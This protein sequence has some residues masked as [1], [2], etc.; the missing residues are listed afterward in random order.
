M[1]TPPIGIDLGTTHSL[2]AAFSDG[3][4]RLIP[5][6]LGQLLTPSVVSIDD[7]GHLLIGQA[8]KER[9][10]T[11]PQH[12]VAAFKRNMGTAAVFS[13]AG[14]QFTAE[15]LS[16]LV[17][18]KLKEDAEQHLGC[19]ITEAVVSVP[20]YFNQTQ[21]QA[22]RSACHIAGIQPIKLINEP[23]AAAL[24]YGLHDR[25]GESQFLVLDLGGGTFD[26]T[27]LEHFD[28]VMEVK[29]SSGD[30]FL[31][32]EDF[33]EVLAKE[34]TKQLSRD[35]SAL[36]TEN[37]HKLRINAEYLK[38]QLS[39]QD[40]LTTH[41]SLEG[42][43]H[44]CTIT[45]E[46]FEQ[47]C[48]HLRKR[49]TTP[50]ERCFYDARCSAKDLDRVVMV[51]G[52]TRMTMFRK[53][54]SQMLGIF[55][56]ALLHPDHAVAL[57]AAVQ[58]GLCANNQALD[59]IVM[60]DVSP[61]SV[62][63]EVANDI[64]GNEYL[65]GFFQPII[66]RNTPLPASRERSF[67]TTKNNQTT[68]LVSLYQGEAPKVIDNIKLGDLSIK[69]PP[70]KAGQESI[71]VRVTYDSSGLIELDVQSLS[72]KDSSSLLITDNVSK[73]NQDDIAKSLK[74]MA[75]LKI[76]PREQEENRA[77]LA[78]LSRL[79]ASALGGDREYIHTLLIDFERTLHKQNP[80]EIDQARNTLTTTLNH[81]D[82]HYVD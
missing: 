29:A 66:E 43:E 40:K 64:V 81:I 49:L 78:R 8:A 12:S 7:N 25:D 10:S 76:H 2:I 16:A 51:G 33:T 56:E 53:W 54:V 70:A 19:P 35:W 24:A 9:L 62:G 38:Q 50:I 52:A 14:T 15:E 77:M 80:L 17:L 23:T 36:S 1:S 27:I 37:Q 6:A 79:Y 72:T 31:G 75:K 58:A 11:H 68:I 18:K 20:A 5:N 22:T 32:G 73:P 46:Q 13:L 45:R 30:A 3:E 67:S 42:K 57:G 26:V 34:L 82:E 4:A 21:R 44:N 60:T 47:A 61:F 48:A 41:F 63:I 55:P 28:G 71:S 65:A 59:D 69:V 39:K 74:K